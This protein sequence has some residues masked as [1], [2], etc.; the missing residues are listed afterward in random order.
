LID[1]VILAGRDLEK[2]QLAAA[3]LGPKGTGWMQTM[4]KA[5]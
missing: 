4:L 2:A 5:S 1:E 3:E